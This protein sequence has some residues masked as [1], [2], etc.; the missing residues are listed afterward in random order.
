MRGKSLKA[1]V[2]IS[3]LCLQSSVHVH[4]SVL[5]VLCILCCVFACCYGVPREP[6][7]AKKLRIFMTTNFPHQCVCFGSHI[8][9]LYTFHE[10]HCVARSLQKI[11]T[12]FCGSLSG[13]ESY[14]TNSIHE[15][16]SPQQLQ[17]VYRPSTHLLQ[18]SHFHSG[19]TMCLV[20][21]GDAFPAGLA[22][23]QANCI[24]IHC[25]GGLMS[26]FN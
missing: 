17:G 22:L 1:Q 13:Y 5:L 4:V 19:P 24:V 15:Q 20:I 7:K 12:S 25:L 11:A 2:P 23:Y 16:S 6:Q 8:H 9:Y 26:S 18:H 3:T 10:L 21:K 14:Q